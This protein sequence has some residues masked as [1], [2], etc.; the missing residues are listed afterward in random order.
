[1]IKEKLELHRVRDF[2]DILNDTILFF[3]QN[4]APL[5]KVFI[6]IC[7][8]FLL[9]GA[10]VEIVTKLRDL[11]SAS[12]GG[13]DTPEFWLSMLFSILSHCSLLITVNAYIVLYHEKGKIA[14]SVAEVWGYFKYYFFRI[15]FAELVL[16]TCHIIAFFMC[17]IPGIY[18]TPI[19]ALIIPI[20]IQENTSLKYAFNQSL[21]LL[22]ESWWFVFGILLL[23]GILT[24]A[25]YALVIIPPLAITG[26]A[27]WLTG[28]SSNSTEIIVLAIVKNLALVLSVFPYIAIALIYY[29]LS[30]EKQ[31][32]SLIN[33]IQMFG[34][35]K[36]GPGQSS[37]EY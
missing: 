23:I 29:S 36:K 17:F 19:I 22:K 5:M 14:P 34:N 21:K 27:E 4:F 12:A 16:L 8:F 28:I 3:R 11:E 7:G 10:A 24:I 35:S 2:G 30:D 25:D 20:M 9:A 6:P 1:M 33:R 15:F 31:G 18:L 37:E 26:G 32:T 13:I